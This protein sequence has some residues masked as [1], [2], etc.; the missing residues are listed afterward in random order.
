[1]KA[2]ITILITMLVTVFFNTTFAQDLPISGHAAA[3]DYPGAQLT[4]DANT[5]YK[6]LFDFAMATITLMT[7][8]PCCRWWRD[9]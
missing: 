4:P 9:T 7:R 3:R 5:E 6:V 1:M 2:K 8:I